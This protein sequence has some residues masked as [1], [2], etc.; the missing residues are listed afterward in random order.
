MKTSTITFLS[1]CVLT[2]AA[3]GDDWPHWRGP[4][5]DA[6]STKTGLPDKAV[7]ESKERVRAAL[8]SLGLALPPQRIT[9]R[10]CETFRRTCSMSVTPTTRQWRSATGCATTLM[11][12][13]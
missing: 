9:V 1:L 2:Q 8:T 3:F 5:L 7:G 10:P 13:T 12:P 11:T 6:V 4:N